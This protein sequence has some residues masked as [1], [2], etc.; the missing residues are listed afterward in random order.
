MPPY[1]DVQACA[2]AQPC[3]ETCAVQQ[4]LGPS[5]NHFILC[6]GCARYRNDGDEF[7]DLQFH[8][9]RC[10]PVLDASAPRHCSLKA[11]RT[12][13]RRIATSTCDRRP[14]PPTGSTTAQRSRQ[15]TLCRRPQHHKQWQV[16]SRTRVVLH[17]AWR[18]RAQTDFPQTSFLHSLCKL[19]RT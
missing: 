15:R 14:T 8:R 5:F 19:L 18:S 2:V 11:V 12:S 13:R 10:V 7:G 3:N 16:P 4:R 6:I 1:V 17:G 9:A